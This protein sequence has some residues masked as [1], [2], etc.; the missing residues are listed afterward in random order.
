MN[1]TSSKEILL[2]RI[3]NFTKKFFMNSLNESEYLKENKSII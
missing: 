2:R 3:S 1:L